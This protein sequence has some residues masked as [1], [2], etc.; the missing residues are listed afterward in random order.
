[1][2]RLQKRGWNIVSTL[3]IAGMAFS[4]AAPVFASEESEDTSPIDFWG[5]LIE[6][7]STEAP[8]TIIVRKDPTGEFTDYTV[9]IDTETVFGTT[10]YNT[11]SMSDWITGDYLHVIGT[12]NENTE[13]V[14]A[15]TIVNSSLNPAVYRGLNGWITSI[16]EEDASLN[17]QWMGAEHE[18]NVTSNT[19][20]VVPGT[21]PAEIDDLEVG[22]RVRVRLMQDSDV[23]GEARIII[24]LRRGAEILLKARTRGFSAEISDMDIEDEDEGTLTVTLLAN[25]HLRS[26]DVNNMVGEEGDEVT[27]VVDENTKLVR[28]YNGETDLEEF[29]EG[30]HVFVVGRVNDDGTITARLV[31]DTDIWRKGVAKH[32]GEIVSIDTDDNTLTL[33]P[34]AGE[35]DDAYRTVTV[36]Y[37]D[38]TVFHE[39]GEE[40]E[41]SD[42][43]VGELVRVRGTAHVED[44]TL[45][46]EYVDDII[47]VD[48]LEEEDGE[49]DLQVTDIDVTSSGV[50]SIT[51][52]NEGDADVDSNDF[53]VYIWI[54]GELDWTYNVSTL[55]D[56][57]LLEAGGVT[58]IQPQELDEESEV[59]VCVDPN[60]EVDESDEDNNCRTETV[61]SSS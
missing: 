16:D 2:T 39:D 30:D 54:D 34:A 48:P 40:I 26:G 49:V 38:E 43:D 32:V 10:A 44:G 50:L 51:V 5:Q 9:D 19:H 22:D 21:N 23:E 29:A 13:V 42:L 53:S 31:K 27:V 4:S 46:I 14:T 7:S 41:E 12:L 45:T 25:P 60:D 20:I 61:G 6:L 59:E 1:M 57:D 24:V 17:V 37:T 28:R 18:V 58:T 56:Q 33:T 8:T 15:D 3:V 35:G 11:T 55:S 52:E 36:E 47:V